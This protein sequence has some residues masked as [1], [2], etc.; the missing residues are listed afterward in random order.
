MRTKIL[1]KL[2]KLNEQDITS[3]I[4]NNQILHYTN[5]LYEQTTTIYNRKRLIPFN[6]TNKWTGLLFL[7]KSH[8]GAE[9]ITKTDFAKSMPAL[10]LDGALK[11]INELIKMELIFVHT[12]EKQDKRKQYIIPAREL[13][14]EYINYIR[15]RYAN[16]VIKIVPEIIV[17]L[18]KDL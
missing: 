14:D 12:D 18:E 8:M 5:Y 17:L 16:A 2:S 3:H 1:Q 9:L 7:M 6:S 10:S 4:N 11:F 15:G 13:T